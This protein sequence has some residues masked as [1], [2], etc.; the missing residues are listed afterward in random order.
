MGGQHYFESL[1]CLLDDGVGLLLGTS[2]A[3]GVPLGDRAWGIRT[4]DR[5]LR[6]V[7][8]AD[9]SRLLDNIEGRIVAV[10]G[11]D[12]REFRSV[13]LKGRAIALEEPDEDDIAAADQQSLA[14]LTGIEETDG[15]PYALTS[16]ILPRRMMTVVVD[17]R[18]GFD[19][20][21]GPTAGEPLQDQR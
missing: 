21:P 6:V 15:T 7:V 10:T 3:R 1:S 16:R 13:Q 20:T 4:S 19:Q 9:D 14:F 17:V 5:G 12:V 2:D 8:G 11:A 18:E